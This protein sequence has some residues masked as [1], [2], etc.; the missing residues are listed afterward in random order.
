MR[1]RTILLG[2]GLAAGIAGGAYALRHA[3]LDVPVARQE[4]DIPVRVFGLG[5]ID[6]R[7]RSRIGFEV[8]GT[9]VEVLA[10]H[11]DRLPAGTVLARLNS[12]FQQA[13]LAKAEAG[14][15]SAEAQGGRVAAAVERATAQYQQ[16]RTL[17]QRRRELAGRGTTSPEQA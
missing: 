11:G 17:A 6:A 10:D 3:P 16:K 7:V 1:I 15:Q 14:L 4:Q 13:R 9:L 12:A 2:L 8:A 5:T